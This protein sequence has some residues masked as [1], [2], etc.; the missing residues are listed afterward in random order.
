VSG[1]SHDPGWLRHR[2]T[3]ESA[4]GAPD[5]AG[6]EALAWDSLATLWAHIEPAEAGKEIVAGHLSGVVTH[7]LTF[8]WRGDLAG[9][10]RVAWRGRIFRV[11]AVH[12]PDE[13]RRFLVLLTREEGP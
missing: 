6:G 5:G 7:R 13:S 12:D 10:M 2:V 3:V 9:G 8:R 1:L 4:A 11:L